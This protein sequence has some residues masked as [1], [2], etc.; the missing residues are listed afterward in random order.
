VD[1]DIEQVRVGLA[2]FG[3]QALL[4]VA[5]RVQ[6]ALGYMFVFLLLTREVEVPSLH[7]QCDSSDVACLATDRLTTRLDVRRHCSASCCSASVWRIVPDLLF[8]PMR[9][10]RLCTESV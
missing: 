2:G 9:S 5:A 10:I 3:I 6:V 1:G 8:R 4:G 7:A